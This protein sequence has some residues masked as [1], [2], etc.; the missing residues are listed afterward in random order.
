MTFNTVAC[1]RAFAAGVLVVLSIPIASVIPSRSTAAG[2]QTGASCSALGTYQVGPSVKP[3]STRSSHTGGA[4]SPTSRQGI[5]VW[6]EWTLS[7]TLTI[8]AYTACGSGTLGSFAVQ[9]ANLG[10]PG[11]ER[12]N[13]AAIVCADVC[14]WPQ[15]G[16]VA[17][18]G[19][20]AQDTRHPTDAMYVTVSATITTT[21]RG[22]ALG[23]PCS[24]QQ[25]CPSPI[26]IT[27]TTAISDITGYLQVASTSYTA[28]S[29][30]PPTTSSTATLSFL[31]PPLAGIAGGS[32]V[33][34]QGWRD[35]RLLHP[36]PSP[37][38]DAGLAAPPGP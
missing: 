6:P 10:P 35:Q 38:G 26:V 2:R 16:I 31:P 23:R 14:S 29:G 34:L 19:T 24:T 11:V 18:A 12:P 3:H 1:R 28:T 15:P 5:I 33:V 22:P 37:G 13:H 9:R 25:E 8:S 30:A 36:I 20:F 32:T 27:S 7:G 17:L 21:R 4:A